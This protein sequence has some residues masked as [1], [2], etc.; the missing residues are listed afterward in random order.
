MRSKSPRPAP[1]TSSGM[2]STVDREIIHHDPMLSPIEEVQTPRP[3]DH[4]QIQIP[5]MTAVPI[6]ET[7]FPVTKR[8]ESIP[9]VPP[10]PPGHHSL[11]VNTDTIH[12]GSSY[13]GMVSARDEP[14]PQQGIR[15][16]GDGRPMTTSN[17]QSLPRKPQTGAGKRKETQV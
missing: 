1:T 15:I 9:F 10:I 14:S 4:Q 12:A 3:D 13:P 17:Q 11:L 16:S 6:K 5:M 2:A 8:R 7:T